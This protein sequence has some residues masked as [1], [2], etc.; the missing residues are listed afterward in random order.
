MFIESLCQTILPMDD[1][2]WVLNNSIIDNTY[3]KPFLR[4]LH[5]VYMKS[6]GPDSVDAGAGEM[7]HNE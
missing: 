4:C 3:K 5:H 7:P 2:L 1:L 6:N